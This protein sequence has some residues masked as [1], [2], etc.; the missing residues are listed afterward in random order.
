[1]GARET[2]FSPGTEEPAGNSVK[3][4]LED[5]GKGKVTLHYSCNGILVSQ[6]ALLR[7]AN[8]QNKENYPKHNL[9]P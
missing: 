2:R 4:A 9:R 1:M 7:P 8:L 6:L 5:G 3:L